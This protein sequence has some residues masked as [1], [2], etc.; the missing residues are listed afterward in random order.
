MGM[1]LPRAWP[2][3]IG[4]QHSVEPGVD[5]AIARAQGN[6]AAVRDELWEGAMRD[7]LG[8]REGTR[9]AGDCAQPCCLYVE[10]LR[11]LPAPSKKL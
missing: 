10:S 5:D 4:K 6:T 9:P 7:H 3:L 8:G 11:T 1:I 2:D